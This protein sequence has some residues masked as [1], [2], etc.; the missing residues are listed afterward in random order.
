MTSASPTV[1][2]STTNQKSFYYLAT[3][4][5][6]KATYTF[7]SARDDITDMLISL[8]SCSSFQ[9]LRRT[10]LLQTCQAT[11]VVS[12]GTILQGRHSQKKLLRVRD[13]TSRAVL[14]R[15]G[16]AGQQEHGRGFNGRSSVEIRLMWTILSLT[17]VVLRFCG[18]LVRRIRRERTTPEV[19]ATLFAALQ[20]EIEKDNVRTGSRG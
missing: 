14:L 8:A 20:G 1:Q 3:G 9:I 6:D 17:L 18:W 12:V 16:K 15:I 7:L 10:D 4:P 5:S 2:R 13:T 11:H 19:E